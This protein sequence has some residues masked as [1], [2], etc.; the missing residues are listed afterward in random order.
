[1]PVVEEARRALDLKTLSLPQGIPVLRVE[2]EDYTDW[3]GQPALRVLVVIAESVDPYKISGQDVGN[4]KAA[5]R[6]ALKRHGMTL[7]PYIFLAKQSELDEPA[8]EE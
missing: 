8:D 3:E 2:T 6:Q 4:L 5:I 1:M 7:F